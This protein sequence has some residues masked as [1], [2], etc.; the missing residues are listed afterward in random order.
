ME[1]PGR[2]TRTCRHLR[3]LGCPCVSVMRLLTRLAGRIHIDDTEVIFFCILHLQPDADFQVLSVLLLPWH[4]TSYQTSQA[5]E[6]IVEGGS[7]AP[8]C[9]AMVTWLTRL[10]SE[11][12]V[13]SQRRRFYSERQMRSHTLGGFRFVHCVCRINLSIDLL[14]YIGVSPEVLESCGIHGK[15]CRRATRQINRQARSVE[16]MARGPFP[17]FA[18]TVRVMCLQRLHTYPRQD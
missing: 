14:N 11:V 3:F 13:F 2:I 9:A 6:G 16:E 5:S 1:G 8:S 10:V 12:F 18:L 4:L 15:A 7:R 17:N